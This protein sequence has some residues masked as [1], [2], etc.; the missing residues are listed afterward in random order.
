M[1]LLLRAYK[2]RVCSLRFYSNPGLRSLSEFDEASSEIF[3]LSFMRNFPLWARQT[4]RIY[5]SELDSRFS[6][7]NNPFLA[8]NMKKYILDSIQF[9]V[10]NKGRYYDSWYFLTLGLFKFCHFQDIFGTFLSCK[11]G[12]ILKTRNTYF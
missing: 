6:F 4:F 5:H 3:L 10:E 8:F 2:Y 12:Q 1:K 7:G 11:K 9:E